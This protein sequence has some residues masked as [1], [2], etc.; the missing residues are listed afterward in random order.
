MTERLIVNATLVN[1]GKIT[2]ADIYIKDGVI[3]EIG[4]DLQH[5]QAETID[6]SG[7]HCLPGMIDDQVHFRE[8]G[9]TNKGDIATESA[10]AVAGGITS[11]MEMP[12]VKPPTLTQEALEAKFQIAQGKS[13]ANYSFYLGASNSN[14]DEIKKTDPNRVCG[15]KVFMG[16]STGNL[17]VD[18]TDALND[19]FREAPTLITT[20]CEYSPTIEKNEARYRE[21][22]GNEVPMEYHPDIRS[23]EACYQSSSFAVDLA[24]KH[25]TRLHVLHIT[26]ADELSL[27]SDQPLT[28]EKRITAEVCAHHLFFSRKDYAEKGSLIKCNPAIKDEADRQAL[29]AAVNSGVIDIIATDHAPHTFEEK[30]GHYF[31]A[32]AGLPLVQHALQSIL[33]HYHRGVF[34]LET[35]VEKTAHAVAT[36]YE[37][38]N[39]GYLREGYAA[40]LVLVDLNKP[41][42]I[43]RAQ[44]RYKCGW[45]PFEGTTFGSTIHTT[46]VNGAPI[47]HKGELQASQLGQRLVFD[48]V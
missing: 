14:I 27:F 39:R 43:D 25:N 40:D 10:A 41:E 11:F 18:D 37:I 6:A 28:A 30:Q 21:Q 33:E 22:Y 8:P 5:K 44:V 13:L 46:L 16:A 47:Y 7:L 20:H 23:R 36:R 17:L 34:S 19:I 31:G 1:E 9:L 4:R 15:V 26:T 32:P 48:R 38:P 24:K 45:S 12:N 35:I 29:L 3:A 2:E 42:T